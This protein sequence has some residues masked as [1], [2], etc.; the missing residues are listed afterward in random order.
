MEDLQLHSVTEGPAL[1]VRLV[2]VARRNRSAPLQASFVRRPQRHHEG[3]HAAS[4]SS[5]LIEMDWIGEGRG[6]TYLGPKVLRNSAARKG[7]WSEDK[8]K[9]GARVIVIV[10]TGC[11]RAEV[12][13]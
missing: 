7:V 1:E 9:L 13:R 11:V 12:I 4:P 10:G 5:E 2:V 3:S 8:G 6:E